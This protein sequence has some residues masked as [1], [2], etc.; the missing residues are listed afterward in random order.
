MTQIKTF[1]TM[2]PA[3]PGKCPECA[4]AHPPE[5]PH[6]RQ[7]LFYQYRY[8]QQHGRFPTW[9]DAMSHCTPETQ[10]AWREALRE[11]GIEI[12]VTLRNS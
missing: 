2:L 11:N 8:H 9:S 6:N 12:S 4:T 1:T 10:A 3:A 7:S 5:Q